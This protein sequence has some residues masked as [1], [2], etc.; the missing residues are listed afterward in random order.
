MVLE[1]LLENSVFPIDYRKY[2][3][4][5]SKN[6]LSQKGF[7]K[8]Y[9]EY[10][11]ENKIKPYTFSVYLPDADF[12]KDAAIIPGKKIAMIFSTDDKRT[13]FIFTNAFIGQLNKTFNLGIN[14]MTLNHIEHRAPKIIKSSSCI[15]R[16][17]SPIV[18]REHD[19]ETNKD[20]FVTIKDAN[21]VS[22]LNIYVKNQ[23]RMIGFK[24]KDVEAF[25]VTPLQ[26]KSTGAVHYGCYVFG[27]VGLYKLEGPS[28]ILQYL[29]NSG[30]GSLSSCGFGTLDLIE[31]IADA[32]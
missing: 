21:F 14:K 4:S 17:I 10:F 23:L 12:K 20:H 5:Y 13:D 29:V 30:M 27:T 24:E 32:S 22:K 7:E 8:F 28:K 2:M 31:E 6:A 11:G 3:L 15:A 25:S 26:C 9:Q 16:S 1:F 19:R 18:V